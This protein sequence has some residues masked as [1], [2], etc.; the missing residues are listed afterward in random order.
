MLSF[1]NSTFP[2]SYNLLY[3]RTQTYK[4]IVMPRHC[5]APIK[6]AVSVRLYES[7]MRTAEQVI[8]KILETYVKNLSNIL[9]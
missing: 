8:M 6:T 2:Q 5:R 9:I 3:R 4:L 1:L 7:N